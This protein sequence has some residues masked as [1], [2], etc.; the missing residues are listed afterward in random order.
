MAFLKALTLQSL[1][2]Q[3]FV[4]PVCFAALVDAATRNLTM[5]DAQMA[6]LSSALKNDDLSRIPVGRQIP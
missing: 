3:T 6:E 5:D 1:G 2:R 4:N